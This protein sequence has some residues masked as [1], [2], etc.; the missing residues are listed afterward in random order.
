MN[1]VF[2]LEGPNQKS[3]S[4]DQLKIA[5]RKSSKTG[6]FP[7]SKCEKQFTT[8]SGLYY[9][10]QKH[11]GKFSYSCKICQQGFSQ[12]YAYRRHMRVHAGQAYECEFCGQKFKSDQRLRYHRSSHTGQYRFKCDK[13][14][15]GYNEKAQFLLHLESHNEN[16]TYYQTLNR[17]MQ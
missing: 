1:E 3:R 4:S 5:K 17:K 14:P 7:C 12:V 10:A 6:H 15:N 8:R 13:C 11:T 2:S 9:H 16:S